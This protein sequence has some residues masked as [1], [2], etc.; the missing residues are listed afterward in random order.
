MGWKGERAGAVGRRERARMTGEASRG[1]HRRKRT[2]HAI[3]AGRRSKMNYRTNS[4]ASGTP[5]TSR[6]GGGRR[7]FGDLLSL[8]STTTTEGS[9]PCPWSWN[10]L[11]AQG[12][13]ATGEAAGRDGDAAENDDHSS[14][15]ASSSTDAIAARGSS[16]SR[17]LAHTGRSTP[18]ERDLPAFTRASARSTCWRSA[19]IRLSSSRR[20][21]E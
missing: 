17:G 16:S 14:T 9:S 13:P 4:G 21:A 20:G 6:G 7:P 11:W 2:R 8:T 19:C 18:P 12:R 10:V 5:N 15:S 1:A 3:R